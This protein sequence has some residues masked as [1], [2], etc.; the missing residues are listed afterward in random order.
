MPAVSGSMR[1]IDYGKGGSGV[2]D[3]PFITD[4]IDK[5][6]QNSYPSRARTERSGKEKYSFLLLFSRMALF[7]DVEIVNGSGR[8]S[9]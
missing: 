7:V 5:R 9:S 1:V 8:H 3:F 2:K 4:T 6:F